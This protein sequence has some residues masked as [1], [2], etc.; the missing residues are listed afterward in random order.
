M[1]PTVVRARLLANY[2][3]LWCWD[4]EDA[5]GRRVESS[6]EDHWD[7][8][9]SPE[10]AVSAGRVRLGVGG[11]PGGAKAAARSAVRPGP[12]ALV[13]VRRD[14]AGLYESLGKAFQAREGVLV[15]RDRRS[16]ERRR[17]GE[18][19]ARERR[20]GDRRSRLEVDAQVRTLGWSAVLSADISPPAAL[21]E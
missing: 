21:L 4:A 10:E 9:G 2:P 7:A 6:W 15:I 1:Q 17:G 16:G 13:I 18:Q 20:R 5:T 14:E 12:S 19:P 8:F 11:R 3:F